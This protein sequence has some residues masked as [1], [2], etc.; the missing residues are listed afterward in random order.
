MLN[1]SPSL[2]TGDDQL[3]SDIVQQQLRNLMTVL[4][5]GAQ[6]FLR[7]SDLTRKPVECSKKHCRSPGDPVGDR[8]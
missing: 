6:P 5:S 1:A 3:W 2:L 8:L 4:E 7:D